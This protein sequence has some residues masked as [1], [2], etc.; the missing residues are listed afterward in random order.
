MQ[1]FGKPSVYGGVPLS[2]CHPVFWLPARSHPGVDPSRVE[3]V[4][5][6]SRQRGDTLRPHVDP[7][8]PTV[9][10][11]CESRQS[12]RTR[13]GG[14]EVSAPNS[15]GCRRVIDC[16]RFCEGN[17][18]GQGTSVS[19]LVPPADFR[20]YT[21]QYGSKHPPFWRFS[22]GFSSKKAPAFRVCARIRGRVR[23]FEVEPSS[24]VRREGGA[25]NSWDTW[26]SAAAC[27]RLHIAYRQA[28]SVGVGLVGFIIH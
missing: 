28:R 17:R 13:W 11:L 23:C 21:Q 4:G 7:Q 20:T 27:C 2:E 8:G 18:G 10:G 12:E 1:P 15:V 5:N 25:R 9:S 16:A 19:M 24:C 6:G 22:S 26:C 3:G 14:R